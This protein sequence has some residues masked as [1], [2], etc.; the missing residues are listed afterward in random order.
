MLKRILCVDDEPNI[1][2]AFERQFHR[3]FEMQT[4]LG[5][6]AGLRMIAEEGPFA[7]VVSDLRMP[8]MDGV[9]FLA[10]VRQLAP[11]TVR[12]MLTGQADLA[13]AI[14]AVN[15]GQVYQFL[16]KP[17]PPDL[18][19]HVLDDALERHRHIT[20]ER[21]LL[22]QTLRGS[23]GVM[24]EILCLVSPV[25]FSRAERIRRYVLHIARELS[26]ADQWQFE[27]AAML[28]QVGC[29]AMPPDILQKYYDGQS[30][31]PAEQALFSSHARI[32]RD[33]LAKIP[34]LEDVAEMVAH[35][36]TPWK[37][38]ESPPASVKIGAH[39]LRV[40]MAFDELVT[41]GATPEAALEEMRERG[42]RPLRLVDALA[43][44]QV[45][46]AAGEV[47]E[48]ALSQLKTGMITSRG[49]YL[50]T[51]I[52]LIAEGQEITDPALARLRTF[53]AT[54]GIEE[55]IGVTVPAVKPVTGQTPDDLPAD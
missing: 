37:E 30:L 35:Q 23:I 36:E 49:V 52:L 20:A 5:A 34:R 28:S 9:R 6:K 29:V 31:D 2:K 46:R 38:A 39:L 26:L 55:P 40:A 45:A 51:G 8:E 18:F 21:E 43:N 24:S 16:T 42:V 1:L 41:R 11:D 44:V 54:V 7:V 14:S 32:A 53:A 17:C 10:R 22:E 12:V 27:L 13:A 50:K 15:Q 19:A 25:A 4:A 48:V 3:R 33:L 47:R